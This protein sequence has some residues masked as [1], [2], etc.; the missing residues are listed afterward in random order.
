MLNPKPCMEGDFNFTVRPL[1]DAEKKYYGIFLS[2]S[3]KDNETY[4]D[5]LLAAMRE[6]NLH[7]LCDRDILSA[8]DDFQKTIESYLDCYAG[9]IIIT[10]NSLKSDWVNYEIGI[11]AG[12]N[13]RVFLYDP[14]NLLT[15][16]FEIPGVANIYGSHIGRY[17]PA[18]HTIPE[19]IAALRGVSPYADMCLE[20][21]A[22]ITKRAFLDRVT[23]HVETVIARL[24]SP[25]IDRCAD[26]FAKCRLSTLVTNFG[27]FYPEHGDGEHCYA[28][29]YRPLV[30][31][32][33][34]VSNR[35]CALVSRGAVSE[36][37]K[38]CVVLNYVL[39]NGKI[40]RAGEKD[41]RG[42]VNETGALVFHMPLH[43]IYGTEFKFF[44]DVP[45]EQTADEILDM[46]HGIG[47]YANMSD[48]VGSKRLYIS[49]PERRGKGLF[50]LDH[51]F[52]NNF[53]CPRVAKAREI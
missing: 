29:R 34:P 22:F 10:E 18:L 19:V 47:I 37:N 48:N 21:N 8:G 24:E 27:M 39:T 44:L 42:M 25:E 46:F 17:L 7:P 53:L 49:I 16:Q 33:C 45:D 40:L 50:R 26:L 14:E 13:T 35:P 6:Q 20:E 9:V 41:V 2:H 11:F 36:E 23:E 51:E 43:K 5:P 38:E 30:D 28:Y 4:L 3:S 32:L 31:G 15:N 12:Q 1:E 52:N